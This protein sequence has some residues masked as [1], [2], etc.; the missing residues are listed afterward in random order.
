M[1]NIMNE[2]V[3]SDSIEEDIIK[4]Y[5]SGTDIKNLSR[6]YLMPASEIK[7]IVKTK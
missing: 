6:Q 3:I 1:E 2:P 5:E 7:K 4:E